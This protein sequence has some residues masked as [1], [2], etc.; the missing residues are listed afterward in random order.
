MKAALIQVKQ[1]ELYSFH[2]PSA[3]IDPQRAAVLQQQMVE[4][5]F[6]LARQTIGQHCDLIVT[7]EAVNFCGLPN[8]LRAPCEDLIPLFPSDGLFSDLAQLALRSRSWLVAGAYNKR[9]APGGKLRCYNSAVVYNRSGQLCAVYDKIHL[10]G[11]ENDFLTPGSRIVTVDTDMG[12]MGLAVCYDMQFPDVCRGC[13]DAGAEF[14]AVPTWGWEHDYGMARVQETGLPLAIAMA[15]PYW[16]PIQGKRS[17]SELIDG[18]GRILAAA[19][20]EAAQL[21]I[22][23]LPEGE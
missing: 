7:T 9:Y 5:C 1:N 17:P 21:L 16:M 6:R 4:Q 12:R 13:K 23:E 15:V 3:H 22:G 18:D 2:D 11:A 8:T 14:M 20:C 10:A 19:G